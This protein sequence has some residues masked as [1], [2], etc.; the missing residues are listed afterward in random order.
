MPRIVLFLTL[1]IHGGIHFLG[2]AKAFHIFETPSLSIPVGPINGVLWLFTTFL[3]ALSAIELIRFKET[4]W[5]LAITAL[6][7]SQFLIVTTWHDSKIGTLANVF[8][9]LSVI[10]GYAEWSFKRRFRKEVQQVLKV[11]GKAPGRLLKEE[12]LE[13]L[14][15]AV[16][17]Y[18]LRSGALNTQIQDTF[19]VR[20]RG[21]LRKNEGSEWMH[22]DFEQVNS[23]RQ[24]MRIFWLYSKMSMLP[25]S[26]L[27]CYKN[28]KAFMD[29]RLLSLLRLEYQQGREM[30]I[31]ETVTWFND[32]CVMYP[33][34]LTDERISWIESDQ[35]KVQA[36]FSNGDIK[37]SATLE[38]NKDHDLVNFY[39]DDRYYSSEDYGMKKY[40]WSTPL[41][42]YPKLN[43]MRFPNHAKAV[44]KFPEGD[45]C[46][47]QFHIKSVDFDFSGFKTE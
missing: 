21:M 37:I 2:F 13:H 32:L 27:H 25:V 34:A 44:W 9:L 41:S 4:W 30:D 11:S 23:I 17:K 33:A 19:R 36:E 7:I 26:G 6:P 5:R 10:A 12:M 38:F 29:I 45:F 28:G 47:G 35:Q 8:I 15:E 20:M 24:P 3:L 42:D 39:S 46:Y 18:I 16:K 1:I 14:P 31:S 43:G 22:L 40:T